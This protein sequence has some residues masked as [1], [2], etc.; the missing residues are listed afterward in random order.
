M[1]ASLALQD[2]NMSPEMSVFAEQGLIARGVILERY[3]AQLASPQFLDFLGYP[4]NRANI[5]AAMMYLID[6]IDARKSPRTPE[7]PQDEPGTEVGT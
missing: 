7:G 3:N 6:R 1:N 5:D 2:L 4:T